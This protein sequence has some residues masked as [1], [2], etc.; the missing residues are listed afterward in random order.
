L[1]AVFKVSCGDG[2][3]RCL[4]LLLPFQ[5]VFQAP[6]DDEQSDEEDDQRTLRCNFIFLC[7]LVSNCL[8]IVLLI[9]F[10]DMNQI[11]DTFMVSY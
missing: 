3:C 10:L 7:R 2:V 5:C 6:V 11:Q 4:F 9:V 8:S 1:F